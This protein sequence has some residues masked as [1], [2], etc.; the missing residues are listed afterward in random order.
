MYLDTCDFAV[1]IQNLSIFVEIEFSEFQ[2]N[3]GCCTH[4]KSQ[5]YKRLVVRAADCVTITV[6]GR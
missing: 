1:S 5:I 3:S 4:I 6:G 2:T